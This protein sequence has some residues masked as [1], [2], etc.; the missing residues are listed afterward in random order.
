MKTKALK[1]LSVDELARQS[2]ELRHETMN[3][4]VQQASGQLENPAR[5]RIVRREIARIHTL[6]ALRRRQPS[7]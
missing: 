6:L 2:V 7:K 5:I 4:R 3:L 1:E